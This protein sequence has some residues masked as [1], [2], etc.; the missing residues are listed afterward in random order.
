MN[1]KNLTK[2]YQIS[3][4]T[5]DFEQNNGKSQKN[6]NKTINYNKQFS[7]PEIIAKK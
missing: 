4:K 1:E 2:K 7:V 3:P 5:L 6:G